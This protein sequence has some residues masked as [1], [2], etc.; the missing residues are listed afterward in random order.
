MFVQASSQDAPNN[1]QGTHVDPICGMKVEGDSGV[2]T[3][4]QEKIIFFCS[5]HCRAKFLVKPSN[6]I[7]SSGDPIHSVLVLGQSKL[8]TYYPLIL[9]LSYLL[10]IVGLVE[11]KHGEINGIR[12][13]T[14][15]MGGFFI[16]F[17]FFKFLDLKGFSD[18]YRTYDVVAKTFPLYGWIYPFLELALGVAYLGSNFL[19]INHI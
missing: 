9:I 3:F 6:Y 15:F 4:Y 11:V 12:M 7:T 10:G 8:K 2:R 18:A 13:M 1:N 16:V 5:E 17:S 19:R 14:N